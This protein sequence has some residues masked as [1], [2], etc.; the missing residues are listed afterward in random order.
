SWCFSSAWCPNRSPRCGPKVVSSWP[1]SIAAAIALGLRAHIVLGV[2]YW[3]DKPLTH[4]EKQYLALATNLI[5]GRGFVETLPNEPAD[6]AQPFSRAPL[7]P[8]F[9]APLT[10]T[11]A[12]LRDG[13]LPADVPLAVKLAQSVVGA[14]GVWLIGAIAR[15]TAGDLAGLAAAFIAAIYPPLVWICAYALS[16]ALYSTIALACVLML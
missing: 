5:A 16:E 3:H 12:E 7:Y 10:L 14:I 4:D 15:R 11:S 8:L 1:R 6:N 2:I 9:L 13:R